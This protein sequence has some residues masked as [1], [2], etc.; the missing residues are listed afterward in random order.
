VGGG[1]GGFL[2]GGGLGGGA[3]AAAGG[4]LAYSE[5]VSDPGA[6]SVV[7]GKVEDL[8]EKCPGG[9]TGGSFNG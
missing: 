4:G 8:I 2:F 7:I 1:I 5:T 6:Q 9:I 3:G